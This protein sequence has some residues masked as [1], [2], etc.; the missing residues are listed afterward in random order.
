MKRMKG[1]A[2]RIRR[3]SMVATIGLLAQQ[4]LADGTPANT[5]I[6]NTAT[7]S[8]SV[9]SVPQGTV[10]SNT[11]EFRVDRK[12]DFLLEEVDNAPTATSPGQNGVITTFRLTNI[13]ND[14]QDFQF[15]PANVTGGDLFSV[16]DTED[17]T[18][19]SVVVDD[20]GDGFP[21][22]GDLTYIDELPFDPT[23]GANQILV[24]VLADMPNA[25]ADG[26]GAI[27]S[28]T[29]TAH[30]GGADGVEGA[31][32]SDDSADADLP[33]TVQN[34]FANASGGGAE[35]AQ[36]VYA[37]ASASL[38]AT[39]SSTVISDP[40][41]SSNPKAVPG[42]VVQYEVTVTNSGASDATNV[43]VVDTLDGNLTIEPGGLGGFDADVLQGGS[44]VLNCSLD[45][46]DSDGDGCGVFP[47]G[48]D[49]EV[50]IIPAT[51][52][53]LDGTAGGGTDTAAT[54]RFQVTIN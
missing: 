22:A 34:V 46:S 35:A 2:S 26:S 11:A 45:D 54:F 39:K 48:S 4:A 38:V 29:A 18:N 37:V 6:Q 47:V 5:L 19:F 53:T 14:T 41:S 10:T 30:D 44:P 24:F 25:V 20:D 1:I 7:A 49:S 31:A 27:V 3:L 52:V 16:N 8:Y 23:G 9:G 13:G 12:I 15:T 40:F 43:G 32:A 17:V 33:G 21:S 28:L 51:G 50:R 42:A 36:D